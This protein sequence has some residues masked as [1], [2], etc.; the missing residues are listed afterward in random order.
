MNILSWSEVVLHLHSNWPYCV[1]IKKCD[2]DMSCWKCN[3]EIAK[4]WKQKSITMNMKLK[5]SKYPLSSYCTWN[6]LISL[7]TLTTFKPFIV[8]TSDFLKMKSGPKQIK[9][10]SSQRSRL[11]KKNYTKS[12]DIIFSWGNAGKECHQCCQNKSIFNI[13]FFSGRWKDL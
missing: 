8:G 11:N 10:I 7:K 9:R 3:A 13:I 2:P 6:F 1:Q 12:F 4:V 5:G